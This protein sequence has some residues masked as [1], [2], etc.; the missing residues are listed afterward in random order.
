VWCINSSS[1]HQPITSADPPPC[2]AS[3]PLQAVL[4]VLQRRWLPPQ[5][6][7]A[8]GRFITTLVEVGSSG[9]ARTSGSGAKG[10]RG[11]AVPVWLARSG[12]LLADI[13]E[14]LGGPRGHVMYHV[15]LPVGGCVVL[16]NCTT[17]DVLQASNKLW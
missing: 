11:A 3:S 7:S 5:P 2:L 16:L 13:M 10:K 4:Q 17:C 14:C 12:Q 8:F 6:A 15:V 9:G 1:A